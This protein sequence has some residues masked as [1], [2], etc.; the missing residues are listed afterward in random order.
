MTYAPKYIDRIK[1]LNEI[2]TD[3]KGEV[4]ITGKGNTELERD[5][6]YNK[7]SWFTKFIYDYG[8]G[9]EKVIKEYGRISFRKLFEVL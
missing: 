9:E 6:S 5:V 7:I 8:N 3:I 1:R 2:A 4:S